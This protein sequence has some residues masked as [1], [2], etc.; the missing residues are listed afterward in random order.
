MSYFDTLMNREGHPYW[1][2]TEEEDNSDSNQ[3]GRFE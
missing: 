1:V 3:N 2:Q